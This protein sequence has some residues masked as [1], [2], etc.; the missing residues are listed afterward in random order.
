LHKQTVK[1]ATERGVVLVPADRAREGV[2][3]EFSVRENVTLAMLPGLRTGKTLSPGK[4]R[5]AGHRWLQ[6]VQAD[7]SVAERPITTLSGGNQQKAVIARWLSVDP[8][9]L[10]LS[11]PTAGIDIGA[12]TTIYE[13]IRHRAEEGLAVLM[14][15]S[16]SEDLLAVCD[17][18][19]V[20]RDGVIV[21]EIDRTQLSKKAVVIA[22][23]GAHGEE[24]E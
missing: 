11:E 1:A 16:D 3:A 23:E 14:S 5:E 17:R 19:I 13:E 24:N 21:T 18:V 22:M 7:P 20:L 9:L 10:A 15:S 2:F 4:D 6:A 12:R 8:K